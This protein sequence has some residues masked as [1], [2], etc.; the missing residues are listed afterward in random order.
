M[1][2]FRMD[3]AETLIAVQE[4]NDRIS[5]I[6]DELSEIENAE[7]ES[8][9]ESD[10]LESSVSKID[11][12]DL[13]TELSDLMFKF[14]TLSMKEIGLKKTYT[15]SSQLAAT[16]AEPVKDCKHDL[17]T[18]VSYTSPQTITTPKEDLNTSDVA[19]P[20]FVK[21]PA[22]AQ[23]P[24]LTS[25]RH[26]AKP[27]YFKG[28]KGE[29]ISTFLEKFQH[30]IT[31]GEIDDP[32]LDLYLLNLVKDPKTYRKLKSVKLTP[33]EKGDVNLL[34]PVIESALLP[35]SEVRSLRTELSSLTQDTT[36]ILEDF[37]FRIEELAI[38]AFS[39]EEMRE[40]GA[41][42]SFL[43]GIRDSELRQKLHESDGVAT[44]AQAKVRAAKLERAKKTAVKKARGPSDDN[45]HIVLQ[46]AHNTTDPTP[47]PPQSQGNFYTA[48]TNNWHQQRNHENGASAVY[49]SGIR[50]NFSRQ[51]N[52]GRSR[53]IN[54]V[55]CWTCRGYGHYSYSCDQPPS[56]SRPNIHQNRSRQNPLNYRQAGMPTSETLAHSRRANQ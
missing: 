36:E 24:G 49:N 11:T 51:Q 44:F 47:N 34:I 31:L 46:V 26:L 32:N 1:T 27:P 4:C 12:S 23:R 39:N 9:V 3:L 7:L 52:R 22:R 42:S 30:F 33:K 41:L 14:H 37:A 29:S 2:D 20:V 38:K 18:A 35:D 5:S 21:Q 54:E 19:T 8:E 25:L 56:N 40:E 6:K 43:G 13:K 53:N 48:P 15:A 17:S 28:E 50:G 55:Q 10:L 45:E 16:F